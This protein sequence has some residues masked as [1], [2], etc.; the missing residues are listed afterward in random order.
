MKKKQY[1]AKILENIRLNKN[2]YLL[3]LEKPTDF[4]IDPGQFINLLID[5][6]SSDPFLRR[7][8]SIFNIK[9]DKI[10]LL[11][12][13]KGKGTK[14]LSEKRKYEE[15]D[16]IGPL[17]RGFNLSSEGNYSLKNDFDNLTKDKISK[18][19]NIFVAGGIGIASVVYLAN[20]FKNQNSKSNYNVLFYGSRDF[21]NFIDPK[22]YSKLF[23]N[24]FFSV[25]EP[26][27]KDRDYYKVENLNIDKIIKKFSFFKGNVLQLIE[28]KINFINQLEN[29]GTIRFYVC[30]P[31]PMLKS[32]V[33]WNLDK[34]FYA[35]LSLESFMGC[36]FKACLGCAV[37]CSDGNYKYVCY[38][39]PVFLWNDIKI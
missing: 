16:F 7:P 17:G 22:Y 23:D 1:K 28:E 2:I 14:I 32:F 34:N 39:G 37:M 13:V 11:Y 9:E 6:Y 4:L 38:D 33:K 29:Y 20:Y 19:I 30:G 36:G 27:I 18:K 35:E 10:F 24:N 5:E 12:Q 25:D 31:D 26:I 15:V 3:V 21:E 8:F